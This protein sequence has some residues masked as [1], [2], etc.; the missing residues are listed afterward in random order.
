MLVVCVL[1]GISQYPVLYTQPLKMEL[2]EG[3]ETSAN[4][5][6]TPG[7]Y[8][9]EHIQYAKHGESLKSR[10]SM[11]NFV[12]HV[13]L[14]LC[15]CIIT[16]MYVVQYILFHCV[17]VYCLCVNVYCITVTGCLCVNVYCITATGWQPSCNYHFIHQ[18]LRMDC[19][20]MRT[21]DNCGE[22]LAIS[23]PSKADKLP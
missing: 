18:L 2:T 6:L 5:N 7:K 23:N 11:F 15:L 13:F 22:K 21:Q 1:L 20:G 14:L 17:V 19:P 16:V 8:P 9:K 4:H 12:K 3:S 10:I